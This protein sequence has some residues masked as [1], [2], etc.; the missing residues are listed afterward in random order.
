MGFHRCSKSVGIACWS[1]GHLV[2]SFFKPL[3]WKK[4]LFQNI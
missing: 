1:P 2:T 3:I 4:K